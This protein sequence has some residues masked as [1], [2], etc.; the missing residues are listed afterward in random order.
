MKIF[1]L[2]KVSDAVFM[3]PDERK[4]SMGRWEQMLQ[5]SAQGEFDFASEGYGLRDDVLYRIG[6]LHNAGEEIAWLD[7]PEKVQGLR[8]NCVDMHEL[9]EEQ[10]DRTLLW[11]PS[12]IAT[13]QS[14]VVEEEPVEAKSEAVGCL[15]GL[16]TMNLIMQDKEY[17]LWACPPLGC[18]RLLLEDNKEHLGSTWYEAIQNQRPGMRG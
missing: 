7:I 17:R 8:G 2:Y 13:S 14:E 18:G 1:L 6:E 15:C 4:E 11:Q 10:I 16:Q 12:I 9:L 5:M 3:T